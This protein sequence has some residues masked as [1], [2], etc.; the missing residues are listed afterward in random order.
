MW[1][2][3]F[4]RAKSQDVVPMSTRS[5]SPGGGF[6]PAGLGHRPMIGGIVYQ[7]SRIHIHQD[8]YA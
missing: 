6:S 4:Q 1:T 2:P 5:D 7:V 8:L 3:A